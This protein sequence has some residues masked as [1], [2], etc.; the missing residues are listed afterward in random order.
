MLYIS[1]WFLQRQSHIDY[2]DEIPVLAKVAVHNDF[3]I[4]SSETP[5]S[6]EAFYVHL[7]KCWLVQCLQP[8]M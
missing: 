8:C 2:L 5:C 7:L 1:G 4:W 6:V 3:M